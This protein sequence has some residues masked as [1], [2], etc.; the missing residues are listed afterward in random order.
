MA[1]QLLEIEE[2]REAY[3]GD[4]E[5]T[6]EIQARKA[7]RFDAQRFAMEFCQKVP[8]KLHWPSNEPLTED[9]LKHNRELAQY[10]CIGRGS[11]TREEIK[12]TFRIPQVEVD[13]DFG[14]ASPR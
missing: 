5:R 1:L 12:T 2:R 9:R 8:H 4:Y 11:I 10:F 14:C 7:E 3:R 6:I 13:L